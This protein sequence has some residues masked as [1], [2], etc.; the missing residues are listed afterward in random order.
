MPVVV[1]SVR[2]LYVLVLHLAA[3]C[4]DDARSGR[5]REPDDSTLRR[6]AKD[7]V[8]PN[9]PGDSGDRTLLFIGT[10]LTAGYGLDSEDSYPALIAGKIDSVA[11]PYDVINAGVSGETSAGALRRID[12][13]LRT[14]ADVI[15][16]ETGAN[17]ALRGL[18]MDSTRANIQAIIDRIESA[19]P[20]AAI[21]LVQMEAPPN[22]GAAYTTGFRSIFPAL[23]ARNGLTLIP[24][25]LEGV[26]G[27][28]ELNLPD[29]VHPTAEGQKIVAANVWRVLRG[30]LERRARSQDN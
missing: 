23:A 4:S 9:A 25:L 20:E 8:P 15:V 30:I 24:F 2:V 5:G 12:W 10:S 16:I 17:D 6:S 28:P 14:P 22:L 29:G 27:E 1:L 11:L 21:V 13:L 7:S 3:A 26:A 18:R 19:Q